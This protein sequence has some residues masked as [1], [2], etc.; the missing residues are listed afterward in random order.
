[1]AD[2]SKVTHTIIMS[3]DPAFLFYPKD[4][5]SG[6]AEYM[7]DEKGVYIDLLCHQ[8]QKGSLPSDTDRLARMVGLSHESFLKIWSVIS[9]HFDRLDNR[10]DDRLVNQKLYRLTVRRAEKGLI[11]TINGTFAGLLR[12]G[13]YDAKTYKHLKSEFDTSLFLSCSKDELSER[14]TEWITERLKSIGNGNISN[15]VILFNKVITENNIELTEEFRSLFL[16]WLKYK[17]EK[18]QTYK[19]TGLKSLLIKSLKDCNNNP[20]ELREMILYSTSKNYDGLFK[21]TKYGSTQSNHS[22]QPK[23]VNSQ[24]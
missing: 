8:H 4:W 13:N 6:T 10:T 17:S 5:L 1:M 12:V 21:E 24:W 16:E 22:G 18:G 2:F 11:N 19:E 15:Y 9:I 3:K 23:N 20:A 14:L 7:P